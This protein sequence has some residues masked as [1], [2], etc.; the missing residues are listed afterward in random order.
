VINPKDGTII[1]KVNLGAPVFSSV[2]PYINGFFTADFGGSVY[3]FI[4]ASEK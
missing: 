1:Q 3:R 4:F 2:T